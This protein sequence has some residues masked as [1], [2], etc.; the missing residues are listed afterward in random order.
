VQILSEM[1]SN[2]SRDFRHDDFVYKRGDR[3]K[4]YSQVLFLITAS[5]E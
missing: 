4:C 2:H 1:L 3:I 5:R